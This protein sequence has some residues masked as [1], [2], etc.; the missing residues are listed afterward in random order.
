MFNSY[1]RFYYMYLINWHTQ[2]SKRIIVIYSGDLLRHQNENT[3]VQKVIKPP[4]LFLFIR[5]FCKS[6][7]T[8][9]NFLFKYTL[10]A[11]SLAGDS[12]Q[13]LMKILSN[14]ILRL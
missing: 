6:P 14:K 12:F 4:F 3:Q 1:E 13:M 8:Y 7:F 9:A 10:H 5:W 2:N 11:I